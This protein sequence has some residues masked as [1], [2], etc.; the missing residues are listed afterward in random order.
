MH[1]IEIL[2]MRAEFARDDNG[3]IWFT[4]ANQIVKRDIP[5]LKQGTEE[6][7]MVKYVNKEH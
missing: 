4:Y 3:T 6:L 5:Q 2:K 1:N 7:K